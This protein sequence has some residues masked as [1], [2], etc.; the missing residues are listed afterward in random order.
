MHNKVT[1][2]LELVNGA[3][4]RDYANPPEVPAI[5]ALRVITGKEGVT[6]AKEVINRLVVYRDVVE[7]I[8]VCNTEGY[9]AAMNVLDEMGFDVRVLPEHKP[10][11]G[12][13]PMVDRVRELAHLALDAGDYDVAIDLI[14]TIQKNV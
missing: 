6:E 8:G 12:P 13:V 10:F 3:D 4:F 7:V 14:K 2:Q 11:S 9:A 5:N 1:I